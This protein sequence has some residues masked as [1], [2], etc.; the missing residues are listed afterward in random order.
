[1]GSLI[2]PTAFQIDEHSTFVTKWIFTAL[3][4]A[5][6]QS[7]VAIILVFVQA[8]YIN[9]IVIRHRLGNEITL[10]PGLLYVLL[11]GLFPDLCRLSPALIANTGILMMLSQIFRTYKSPRVADNL[12]NIGFVI[13]LVA[14]LVPHYIYLLVIGFVGILILRS[15]KLPEILQLLTGTVTSFLITYGYRYIFTDTFDIAYMD[16]FPTLSMEALHIDGI[17]LV[18]TLVYVLLAIVLILNYRSYTSKKSI[19]AQKKIDLLFWVMLFSG[20]AMFMDG[21][22]GVGSVVLMSIPIAIFLSINLLNIKKPMV[23]ELIHL[24]ILAGIFALHFLNI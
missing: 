13:G 12:F 19:Q 22:M 7:I 4:S 2:A 15:I 20:V 17:Q 14:L 24:V 6:L 9:R 10:I 3:P 18:F 5:L 23:Q 11:T 16:W 21:G 1:M 8:A